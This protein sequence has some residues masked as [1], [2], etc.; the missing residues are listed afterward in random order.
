M[1][2]LPQNIV[3]PRRVML[4]GKKSPFT[5]NAQPAVL[6]FN[7]AW[8]QPCQDM[9]SVVDEAKQRFLNRVRFQIVDVDDK[10]N[11]DLVEHYSIGPVPT[12]VFL[13]PNGDVASFQVGYAGVDGMVKGLQK[14]LPATH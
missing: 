12:T 11:A 6:V 7:A 3:A 14:I 1:L 13:T 2:T 4:A 8:C 10:A 9:N 5:P